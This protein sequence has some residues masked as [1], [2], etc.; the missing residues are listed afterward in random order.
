MPVFYCFTNFFDHLL[1]FM[2]YKP[3]GS[4]DTLTSKTQA[5]E[6]LS[7]SFR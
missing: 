2:K 7:V 4:P 5:P 6:L 1:L 3:A